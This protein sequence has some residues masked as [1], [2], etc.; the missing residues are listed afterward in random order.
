[1]RYLIN[2]NFASHFASA[3]LKTTL[4]YLYHLWFILLSSIRINLIAFSLK[5]LKLNFSK[6]HYFSHALISGIMVLFLVYYVLLPLCS[7]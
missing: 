5:H 7:L 2:A 6:S 3:F 1:M 4:I